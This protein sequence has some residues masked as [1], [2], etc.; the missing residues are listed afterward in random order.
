MNISFKQLRLWRALAD[1]GSVGAAAAATH[2]TQPTA[3][4]QLKEITQAVG[5]PLYEVVSRRVHL[6]EAGDALAQT[7]RALSAEW[8]SFEQRMSALKGHQTGR[9]RLSM[10]STA[11][12]FVPRQVGSFCALYPDVEVSLE[13]LN[14]DGVLARLRDN[15]DDLYIMSMPPSDMALQDQVFRPNPLVVI[16]AKS[17]PWRHLT[18]LGLSS[19]KTEK[20]ILREKGSGTRMAVDRHFK[21][22]PIRADGAHG[23]GQQRSDQ[24][25]GGGRFGLVGHL[26]PC[27]GRQAAKPGLGGVECAGVSP[28]FAM[29]FGV[30]QGQ[31]FVACGLGFSSPFDA[32]H[33]GLKPSPESNALGRRRHVPFQRTQ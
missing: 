30:P 20:F 22:K 26:Q 24:R 17:H 16:A 29:A 25:C 6:T 7:A 12:Y 13:V 15:M 33:I 31:T 9:L 4:M 14:R 32:R 5:V 11:K 27:P 1:T 2:V 18:A 8:E 10:V 28:A 3:S 21:K 23:F 19:L